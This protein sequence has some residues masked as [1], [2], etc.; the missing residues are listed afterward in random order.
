M[1]YI[2]DHARKFFHPAAINDMLSTFVPLI[3]G[4]SLDVRANLPYIHF[5]PD[6]FS[7]D[8]IFSLPLYDFSAPLPSS[9][10]S[11]NVTPFLG[12][13]ELIQV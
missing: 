11:S 1:G 5:H 9:K 7:E 10:L 4:T 2:A 12:I 8:P 13:R 3:D 6:L